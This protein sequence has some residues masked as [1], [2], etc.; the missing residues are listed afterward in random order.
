MKRP[1]LALCLI[2]L[3]FAIAGMGI[4][5]HASLELEH[6][7]ERFQAAL[8]KGTVFTYRSASPAFLVRGVTLHDVTFKNGSSSFH[9]KLIRLGHPQFLPGGRLTLSS[10]LLKNTGYKTPKLQ[11]DIKKII[12]RHLLIPA[13]PGIIKGSDLTANSMRSLAMILT[14]N[15]E[16][17]TSLR[18]SRTHIEALNLLFPKAIET[19]YNNLTIREAHTESLT[20]EGYGHGKRVY[21]MLKNLSLGINLSKNDLNSFGTTFASALLFPKGK[22]AKTPLPAT[23]SLSY[24]EAREGTP[25]LLKRPF[26]GDSQITRIFW[27][28]PLDLPWLNTGYLS[29]NDLKLAFNKDSVQNSTRLDSLS[30]SRRDDN[31]GIRTEALLKGFHFRPTQKFNL[32][33]SVNGSQSTLRLTLQNHRENNLWQGDATARLSLNNIGNLTL[34]SHYNYPDYNPLYKKTGLTRSFAQAT[35]F[36][37]TIIT[38]HGDHF[39]DLGLAF[40]QQ[41]EPLETRESL[42]EDII[43]NLDKLA[44]VRSFISPLADFWTDPR[45][46]TLS[47]SLGNISPAIFSKLSPTASAENIID[48]LHVTS[49]NAR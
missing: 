28:R 48:S 22:N 2:A 37:N 5:R 40:A 36:N 9:A 46:R 23:L 44:E 20:L 32:P 42:R 7:V 30:I 3:V 11:L 1:W 43:H 15:P 25:H 24:L 26:K 27:E 33:F 8:P 6:A 35:E 41:L 18:F 10:L 16:N 19:S 21:G 38:M 39:I 29:V 34:N 4:Y 17:L 14:F 49:V 12:F 31:N 47:I 13:A 45:D